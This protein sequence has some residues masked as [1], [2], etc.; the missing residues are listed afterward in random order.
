[1]EEQRTAS[2]FGVAQAT[3]GDELVGGVVQQEVET[4]EVSEL[5]A[6]E[7]LQQIV[8]AGEA[9]SESQPVQVQVEYAGFWV[10]YAALFVDS[11]VL[12]IP[13]LIIRMLLGGIAGSILQYVITLTYAI[14]M[15]NKHQA[16]LGKMA[17]GIKVV[18]TNGE[19]VVLGKLALREIIGKFLDMITL[20]IGYLMVIVTK[21]KQTLHD[22]IANTIVVYDPA[23]KRRPWL[24]TLGIVFFLLIPIIGG[25]AAV[26]IVS[27]SNA[28][29]KVLEA[30]NRAIEAQLKNDALQ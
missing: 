1:M 9:Q 26:V 19:K 7:Q 29:T 12:V 28:R 3:N 30:Q 2:P 4:T 13:S 11:L 16:T 23:R 24:T 21:Q 17:V 5:N 18:S 20:G 15:L 14:Y 22:K 10:R 27:T 8:Q 25:I 6:T